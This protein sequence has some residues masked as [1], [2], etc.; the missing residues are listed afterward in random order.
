LLHENLRPKDRHDFHIGFYPALW[1]DF[2][3]SDC[4]HAHD[5]LPHCELEEEALS[6]DVTK[7]P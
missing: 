7:R 1:C 5:N 4:F 3:G 6:G 2:I